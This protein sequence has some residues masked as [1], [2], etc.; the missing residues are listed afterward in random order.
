[1]PNGSNCAFVDG[2]VN[3]IGILELL[4]LC[5]S[6][7]HPLYNEYENGNNMSFAHL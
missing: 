2:T 4:L 5:K 7:I 3:S 1:M 6:R